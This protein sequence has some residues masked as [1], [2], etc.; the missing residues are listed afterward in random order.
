MVFE[1]NLR[2]RIIKQRTAL[3]K[4]EQHTLSKKIAEHIQS[5][6]LFQQSQHIAFY[7]AVNGEV[8]PH[9]LLEHAWAHD[10]TCYLPTLDT[11]TFNSLHFLPYLPNTPL[12]PNRYGI[13][14]PAID[15]TTTFFPAEHLDLVLTP[16]V[17]FDL[18]GNRLGMGGGY[19]DR[20][21]AFLTQPQQKPTLL[22]L[23]YE[24]QKVDSLPPE[25]WDIPLKIT[26]TD[27]QIYHGGSQAGSWGFTSRK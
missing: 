19:Y 20:T 3:S 24:F 22:G 1:T 21:F 25:A 16:L 26:A 9:P 13:P 17:A 7:I 14:E 6:P 8:D 11:T 23:A 18:N 15:E 10:K 12:Q 2:T 5:L 27:L 4:T